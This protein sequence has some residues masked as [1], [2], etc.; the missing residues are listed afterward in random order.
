[1]VDLKFYLLF[2]FTIIFSAFLV[3]VFKITLEETTVA[4]IT[5]YDYLIQFIFF[6]IIILIKKDFKRVVE[7]SSKIHYFI[8]IAFFGLF[9]NR[10][11]YLNAFQFIPATEAN[12]LYYT[13][14]L[15]ISVLGYFILK[16]KIGQKD[17][18]GL[19]LGFLAAFIVITKFDFG[20]LKFDLIGGTLA[21]LGGASYGLYLV[22]SKKFRLDPTIL[23][24]YTSFFTALIGAAYL[25]LLSDFNVSTS[26]L[27]K[28]IYIGVSEAVL[29]LLFIELLRMKSTYR[30]ANLFYA[31]PFLVVIMNYFLLGEMI[32]L[33]YII[34]LVLLVSGVVIQ[35]RKT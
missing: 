34:G 9:L 16:E 6:S 19:L 14:P 17:I 10:F 25:L 30:V 2:I 21:I 15:T 12:I 29:L 24:F 7:H 31:I 1:M 28:M 13:Y 3:P 8:L 26:A 35:N 20:L 22:F 5:F 4:H 32:Q 33:S 11:L 23:I 27:I 18:A